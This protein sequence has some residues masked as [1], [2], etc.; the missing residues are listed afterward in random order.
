VQLAAE[1]VDAGPLPPPVEHERD[2]LLA[3]HLEN[4]IK[5]LDLDIDLGSW[6]AFTERAPYPQAAPP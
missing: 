3:G 6:S 5:P 4:P 1:L 2:Y